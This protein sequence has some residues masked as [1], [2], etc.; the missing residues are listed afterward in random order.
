MRNVF[1]LFLFAAV[2]ATACKKV[3][4]ND[5]SGSSTFNGTVMLYDTLSGSYTYKALPAQSIFLKYSTANAGYLYS[6]LSDANGMFS[7]S[8]LDSTKSY[9]IYS[10]LSTTMNYYGEIQ[11]SPARLAILHQPDTLKLIPDE[12]TQN[13]LYYN[14]YDNAGGRLA[15]VNCYIYTS[16]SLWANKDTTAYTYLIKSDAAGRCLKIGIAPAVYYIYA[17]A[18]FST[19]TLSATDTMKVNTY[20]IRKKALRLK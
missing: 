8:P 20:G 16:Q 17:L 2:F 6:I 14:L 7:F 15:N 5:L 3:G 10:S 12:K 18:K 1:I 11:Y 13:G 4:N 9:T 19:A